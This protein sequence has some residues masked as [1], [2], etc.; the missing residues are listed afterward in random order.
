MSNLGNAT[1]VHDQLDRAVGLRRFF[2]SRHLLA[3]A[4][5]AIHLLTGDIK[6]ALQKLANMEI[7]AAKAERDLKKLKAD[8]KE[9]M[10][11]IDL[12]LEELTGRRDNYKQE[13]PPYAILLSPLQYRA[14]VTRDWALRSGGRHTPTGI[15]EYKKLPIFTAKGI[16]GPVVVTELAFKCIARQ[17]PEL[18][19][20][21]AKGGW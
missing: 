15:P 11:R 10:F 5:D 20:A 16:Y 9:I 1:R 14:M 13:A 2:L 7:R 19:I 12:A 17:A 8:S 18:N 3:S 21:G 4:R 6:D